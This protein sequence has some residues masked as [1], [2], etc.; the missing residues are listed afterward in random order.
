M[1][2]TFERDELPT[3]KLVDEPT[4]AKGKGSEFSSVREFVE[5]LLS[6][7]GSADIASRVL[8]HYAESFNL[9]EGWMKSAFLYFILIP[10]AIVLDLA[11]AIFLMA[12]SQ[13]KNISFRFSKGRLLPPEAR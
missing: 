12:G 7:I 8:I 5:W 1:S 13:E 10:I 9:G 6:R 2:E 4:P 3:D 11:A